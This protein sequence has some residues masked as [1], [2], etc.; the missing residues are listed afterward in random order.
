MIGRLTINE[1][2]IRVRYF[3]DKKKRRS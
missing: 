3:W 1:R 2:I